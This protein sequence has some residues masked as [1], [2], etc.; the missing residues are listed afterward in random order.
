MKWNGPCA[1]DIRYKIDPQGSI[2]SYR[3]LLGLLPT[4]RKIALF[5]YNGNWDSVVPYG[6]TLKGLD[7]LDIAGD[8][9]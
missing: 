5:L 9:I 4:S 7:M 8:Y 1:E 2:N 3:H 6:D